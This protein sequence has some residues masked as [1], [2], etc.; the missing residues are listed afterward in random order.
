MRQLRK[1]AVGAGVSEEAVDEAEDAEDEKAALIELI[2]CRHRE[3]GESGR[4]R[5]VLEGGGEEALELVA[6]VLEQ[7]MEMLEVLASSTPR[8][9]RKAV[10]EV[11]ERAEAANAG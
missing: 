1:R 4:V 5:A 6:S 3:V 9:D 10:R 7:A 8:K 2:V 11:L